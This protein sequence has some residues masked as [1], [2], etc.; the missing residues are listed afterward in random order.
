MAKALVIDRHAIDILDAAFIEETWFDTF[1]VPTN[2]QGLKRVEERDVVYLLSESA[3]EAS[4]LLVIKLGK[5]G[6]FDATAS[7]RGVFERI[8][9][10]ALR[11]FDRSVTVPI[12]WQPF[13]EGSLLSVYAQP[14]RRK[15]AIRIYFDHAP[16]GQQHIYAYTVDEPRKLSEVPPDTETYKLAIA[17]YEDAVLT[18]AETVAPVG[19]YGILLSEPFGSRLI[20]GG[21]INEWYPRRL[22][23]DQ[24]KFVREPSDKPIR[25]RGAAGTGKTQAMT[26]KCLKELY[27]DDA[28]GGTKTTAF[29]T[30]SSALAHEVVKGMFYALDPSQKWADL[31]TP[32]GKPKLW[33]GTIYE[34]AAEHLSYTKKGLNPLS[35]DGMDGRELQRFILTTALE[36]TLSD[37]RTALTLL[38]TSRSL[39]PRLWTP[40]ARP[41]LI[42]ELSIEFGCVLDA[43]NIRRGTDAAARYVRGRREDWQMSLPEA[44][45]RLLVLEIYENYKRALQLEGLLSLDQ[46]ITDFG[47]YLSTHEWSQLRDR[48]GF[49]TVFIDEYHYFSRLEVMTLHSLFKSRAERSSKWPLIMAY[50]LKQSLNDVALS[51]GI[52]R[53]KNPGVGVSVP[54]DLKEIYRS[55]PQIASFLSDF[56]GSFP[57]LDLEGEYQVY[58]ARS[59]IE[60]GGKP[61]I[62][63]FQTDTDLIDSVFDRAIARGRSLDGGGS[64][65]AVLCMNEQ[66][67]DVYRVASRIADKHIA[68][69]SREDLRELR[70]AKSRCVFSMPDYVA[71]LQFHSVFLIHADDTDYEEVQG[72]PGARRR[73]VT[74]L[75]LGASRA[76]RDLTIASS[77][78]R[79]GTTTVLKGAIGRK[80]L[81]SLSQSSF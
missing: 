37:P 64:Q 81:I 28:A 27:E 46:M 53:F 44:D 50:D 6:A 9:R 63:E 43:E 55:T 30:H 80:S 78:A 52:D 33:I 3:N 71:G 47:T 77:L 34:L 25:L 79:G 23:A 8:C 76:A 58:V 32:D 48:D 29:L 2:A 62:V 35:L 57:A 31:R 60:D 51:G 59:R 69:T 68:V 45:D 41:L 56:D 61:V 75:Y 42:E 22:N 1:V 66:L 26:I 36:K 15:S 4:G 70:Y 11:H 67:F 54:L 49:D 5:T 40:E 21:G 7:K 20:T 14:I 13:H 39:A 24:L 18:D 72:S 65:V 19:N 38:K 74:R 17:G 12:T 16:L 73:Y 10:V